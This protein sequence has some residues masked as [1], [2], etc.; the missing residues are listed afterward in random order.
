MMT[1]RASLTSSSV[2]RRAS[3]R[4]TS[5]MPSGAG[6]RRPAKALVRAPS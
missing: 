3:S 2:V 5:N 1:I 6:G 4:G